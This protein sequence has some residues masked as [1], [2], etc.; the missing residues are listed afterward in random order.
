LESKIKDLYNAHS[1]KLGPRSV[2]NVNYKEMYQLKDIELNQLVSLS[3]HP[4]DLSDFS[5]NEF[6]NAFNYLSSRRD[7]KIVALGEVGL[8]RKRGIPL[9]EQLNIFSQIVNFA[10]EVNLPLIIHCVSALDDILGCFKKYKYTRSCLFHDFNGNKIMTNKLTEIGHY[11]GVGQSLWRENS[12]IFRQLSGLE[13]GNVLLETDDLDKSI[14]HV[15]SRYIQ[16][17]DQ[18]R[19]IVLHQI[20][21][22][23][24]LF[25]ELPLNS[26]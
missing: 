9:K 5:M 3:A 8:D 23:F 25:F 11:I 22:N 4:W 16:L 21:S 6:I 15:Y 2:Y 12:K 24:C 1:H 19:E 18:P 14:D 10:N 17:I 20:K 7:L 26:L 13:I